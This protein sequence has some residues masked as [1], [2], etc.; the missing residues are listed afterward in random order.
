[1]QKKTKKTIGQNNR[2]FPRVFAC[3]APQNTQKREESRILARILFP[4]KNQLT[5]PRKPEINQ[6]SHAGRSVG[7]QTRETPPWAPPR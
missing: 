6:V 2:G 7:M 4:A 5:A 1:M 3:F